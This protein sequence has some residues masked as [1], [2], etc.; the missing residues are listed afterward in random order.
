MAIKRDRS[1]WWHEDG[2]SS[3]QRIAADVVDAAVGDGANYYVT[4]AGELFV[5]GLAHRGQYGNGQLTETKD[6]VQTA[7]GVAGVYAHTGHALY[8]ARNGDVMG[9][10]GNI[11]G[12]VGRHGLGDK[13]VR[14]SLLVSGATGVAT[15]SSHSHTILADGTLMVWGREYGPD[16]KPMMA[17]VAAVAA[18]SGLSIAL[19]T[20]GSIWQWDR[21]ETPGQVTLPGRN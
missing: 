13:A 18:A 1:L 15:G 5:K 9:T 20:D 17:G 14:W 8:L 6:Y 3:G 21:G 12:P 11:Y 2:V 4:A 10:G 16:P 7:T 19:K